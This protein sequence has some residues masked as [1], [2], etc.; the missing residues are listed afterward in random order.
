M[1]AQ[2]LRTLNG[3]V[4]LPGVNQL[5]WL[6]DQAW[7]P[8]LLVVLLLVWSWRTKSWYEIGG[9]VVAVIIS[10]VLCA[11][12]LKPII[13]RPRPCAELEWVAAPFGC[14]AAFAMPSCHATNMF[15][16]AMVINK[17]WAFFMAA[18]VA[19]ARSIAGVHYPSDLLAGAVLGLVIG[20]VIRYL[21]EGLRRG[22]K[23]KKLR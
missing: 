15:A 22:A 16:L 17:P 11:R 14:G 5:C 23:R 4:E 6:V 10:D 1:D 13:A 7:A 8:V 18:V 9:V 19:I 21:V 2:L 20:W 3:L 12:V